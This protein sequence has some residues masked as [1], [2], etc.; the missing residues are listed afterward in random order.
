[1]SCKWE[2]RKWL[3][4]G[5][6]ILVIHK[7]CLTKET[8]SAMNT[9]QKVS[10]LFTSL[11][12]CTKL[13]WWKNSLHWN[14]FVVVWNNF[15][16]QKSGALIEN[17]KNLYQKSDRCVKYVDRN[18]SEGDNLKVRKY[19][20]VETKCTINQKCSPLMFLLYHKTTT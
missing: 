2:S 14:V 10:S 19:W 8:S 12:T 17:L 1:M 9:W 20:K 3:I 7:I 5:N 18:C 16:N 15:S 6:L 13:M 4:G 11:Q